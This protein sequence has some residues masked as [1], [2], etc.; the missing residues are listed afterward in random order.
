MTTQTVA[1]FSLYA[2]SRYLR[3]AVFIDDNIYNQV[4]A[5]PDA[6]ANIVIRQPKEVLRKEDE[7][8]EP[9][10]EE[11]SKAAEPEPIEAPNVQFR[12]KD[13]VGSFA[14]HGIVCALYE[15]ERDFRTDEESTVFKL[16]NAADLI[17][18]DWDFHENGVQGTRPKSL[19]G[20]LIRS[21]NVVSPHHVRLIAIYT[22]TQSLYSISDSIY[23]YLEQIGIPVDSKSAY[24]LQAGATRIVILGKAGGAPR[25]EAEKLFTV[26]ESTLASRLLKEFAEMN[27]GILPSC[28]LLGMAA[29]RDNSRRILDKFHSTLDG[30]FLFHRALIRSSE[31]AFEQLPELLG[32]EFRAVIEDSGYRPEKI[33]EFIEKILPDIPIKPHVSPWTVNGRPCHELLPDFLTKSNELEKRLLNKKAALESDGAQPRKPLESAAAMLS[34][35]D[36]EAYRRFA[37]LLAIRT[38]YQEKHRALGFGVIIYNQET[39]EYSVCIIPPCD[40]LRI[41]STTSFPFWKLSTMGKGH[42][43]FVENLNN[44]LLNLVFESGKPSKHLWLAPF[45]PDVTKRL[46]IATKNDT[47]KYVFTSGNYKFEWVAQLKPTHAQRIANTVGQQLSRVGLTEA[48]WARITFKTEDEPVEPL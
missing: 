48:E 13:L 2:A 35:K 38:Q 43:V 37:A 36:P 16:C 23:S 33:G 20:E 26:S 19:I 34:V 14:K 7:S 6:I 24:H 29:I 3:S 18:L 17:A 10:I 46:V 47:N 12:T 4:T 28:A 11:K 9:A 27:Q 45:I 21:G 8:K 5:T 30:Q 41:K 39:K 1:E 15:P 25:I 32:D 31:E 42:P 44:E 22:N 40:A